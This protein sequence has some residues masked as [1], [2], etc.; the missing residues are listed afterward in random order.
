MPAAFVGAAMTGPIAW[1]GLLTFWVRSIAVGVW[2][3]VMAVVLGQAIRRQRA[4]DAA[5]AE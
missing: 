1:N 5:V 4:E 2:I 3:V